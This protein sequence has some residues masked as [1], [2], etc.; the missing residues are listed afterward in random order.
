MTC[1]IINHFIPIYYSLSLNLPM[2]LET[3]GY[4]LMFVPLTFWYEVDCDE[5]VW[6]DEEERVST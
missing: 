6:G 4:C 1:H 5:A 3:E 2:F